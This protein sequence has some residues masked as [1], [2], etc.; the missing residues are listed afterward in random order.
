MYI[1]W[2]NNYMVANSYVI[3]INNHLPTIIGILLDNSCVLK[4]NP[5]CTCICCPVKLVIN[6]SEILFSEFS[7]SNCLT[8]L[9]KITS[10]SSEK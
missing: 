1:T 3:Y 4:V 6:K 7:D 5:T 10:E 8:E 9:L 2:T